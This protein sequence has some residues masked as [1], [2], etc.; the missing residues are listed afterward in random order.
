MQVY[1]ETYGCSANQAE[2]EMLAGL[3]SRAG[4]TIVQDAG[5]ADVI[6][7]NT[8]IVK[9]ST[10]NKIVN[11]ICELQKTGK[12]LIIAGCM[13][14]AERDLVKEYAPAASLVST[15][16]I[17]EI[18]KAVSKTLAGEV[19][20]FVGYKPTVKL[21]LPR[22]RKNK[23]TEIVP[24][25]SGCLGNCAYCIVKAAKG[26][27][28]SYP[29]KMIIE[30]IQAAKSAGCKQFWLTAQDLS[31]YGADVGSSLPLLLREI[32]QKVRGEYFI[33]L[34]MMNPATL[35]PIHDEMIETY[36]DPHVY[37]FLHLPVQSGANKVLS[38]MRRGY[39]VDQF[40]H[41]ATEFRKAFPDITIST[42]VIAGFPTETGADFK[43]T[44]QLL[45][46]IKPDIVNISKF[47][48]RPATAAAQMKSLPTEIPK[49]RSKKLSQ[50]C[51]EIARRRNERYLGKKMRCLVTGRG[52]ARAYNFKK[53]FF[54]GS[55][56]GFV[57]IKITGATRT[58]LTGCVQA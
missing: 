22:I 30:E 58:H 35:W 34:G 1:I 42:D 26:E 31:A 49:E 20:E 51:A 13:P 46:K 3:L 55:A 5:L 47:Y 9:S 18:G 54:S 52:T 53:V 45:K 57:D 24:I 38:D 19:I 12:K 27:L 40:E 32:L 29:A 50:L 2:S 21:C 41:I 56:A 39:T 15:H 10:E 16:H 36:N 28:F 17:S 25:C 23:I 48:T 6:I 33:R 11:R 44:V 8:C 7:I 14:E 43:K 37:R 4:A